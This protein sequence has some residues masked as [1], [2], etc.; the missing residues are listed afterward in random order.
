ME[1]S[2]L[3]QIIRDLSAFLDELPNELQANV[4]QLKSIMVQFTENQFTMATDG[5]VS[6]PAA[7]QEYNP[8]DPSLLIN[9]IYSGLKDYIEDR[10]KEGVNAELISILQRLRGEIDTYERDFP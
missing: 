5:V 3:N 10:R 2:L 9:N 4:L 1:K 6:K 8:K 7:E